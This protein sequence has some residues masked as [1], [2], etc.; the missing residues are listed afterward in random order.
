[1]NNEKVL[2]YEAATLY[3]D[4]KLTQQEIAGRMKLSRQTV[5]RLLNDAIREKVVEIKIHDPEQD[6]EALGKQICSA[7][8]IGHC[9]VCS[10]SSEDNATRRLMTVKA[11]AQYLLPILQKGGRKI[12][13]SWGRTIQELINIFPDTVTDGNTVFPLFGATDQ[14]TAYFSPNELARNMADKLG[15]RLRCAWFPYRADCREDCELLKTLSYYQKMQ[16]L[17][18]S[19]DLMILGIGNTE[20]LDN[21][22]KTF[23]YSEKHAQIVG[24]IATHFFEKD[25]RIV[26]LYDNTLCASED[27]IRNAKES[28]AIACGN[29]KVYAIAGALRTGMIDTL[30]TDERTA[31]RLLEYYVG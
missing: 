4:G 15:A 28:V 30:I 5:S 10:V 17:W 26:P 7:F 11:A 27:D 23:G 20:T 3:Y 29:D 22:G 24:D 14:E 6:R 13:V 2:M 19:A 18:R 21:L 12:A 25:G 8:G 9:V 1:M 31:R 16:Q